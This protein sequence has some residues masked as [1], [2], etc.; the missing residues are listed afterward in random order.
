MR[1]QWRLSVK[2][3]AGKKPPPQFTT[4]PHISFK[5]SHRY[6]VVIRMKAEFKDGKSSTKGNN[7]VK[8]QY[9]ASWSLA[10]YRYKNVF[11]AC[12]SKSVY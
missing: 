8:T 1:S 2:I 3:E 9:F 7:A 10:L 12:F 4:L 11:R 6:V 5:R